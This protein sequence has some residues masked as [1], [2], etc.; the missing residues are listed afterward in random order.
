MFQAITFFS[1]LF[2]PKYF[3]GATTK[4]W[5]FVWTKIQ[6][7]TTFNS[8]TVIMVF[9][10]GNYGFSKIARAI[11][12]PCFGLNPLNGTFNESLLYPYTTKILVA[13]KFYPLFTPTFSLKYI[14]YTVYFD[15][16]L[17]RHTGYWFLPL[18]EKIHSLLLNIATI[19]KKKGHILGA[20]HL[21]SW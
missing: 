1:Y 19:I 5:R 18:C 12:N 3:T 14:L 16:V 2:E 11:F 13:W 4:L 17:L 10:K 7:R 21:P 6:I 8:K 15:E 9:L 20:C